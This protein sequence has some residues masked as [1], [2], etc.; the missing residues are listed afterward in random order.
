MFFLKIDLNQILCLRVL[1][2]GFANSRISFENVLY[3]YKKCIV[4]V[5]TMI[6]LAVV[7]ANLIFFDIKS[8]VCN[9]G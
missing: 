8:L 9:N 1:A 4:N 6:A 5:Y 3:E 7:A 2:L